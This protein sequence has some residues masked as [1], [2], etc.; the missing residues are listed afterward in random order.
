MGS[1]SQ[2]SLDEAWPET[3]DRLAEM[4]RKRGVARAHIEDVVQETAVRVVENS[5]VFSD[6]EDLLRWA[7]VVA[8]RIALDARRRKKLPI[9]PE[10]SLDTQPAAED[11]AHAA[12]ARYTVDK[13]ATAFGALTPRE[14][15]ALSVIGTDSTGS[16]KADVRLNV[17]RL[18]ARARLRGLMDGLAGVVI[19]L[20]HAWRPRRPPIV[21]AAAVPVVLVAALALPHM[22]GPALGD[23]RDDPRTDAPAASEGSR[24]NEGDASFRSPGPDPLRGASAPGPGSGPRPSLLSQFVMSTDEG[25]AHV[26]EMPIQVYVASIAF[27]GAHPLC[28]VVVQRAPYDLC[29]NSPVPTT[30]VDV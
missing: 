14:Q 11:V 8:W 1:S 3:A 27:V 2:L 28:L 21:V 4:L 19:G 12:L 24:R 6:T 20:R 17:R 10:A 16:R 25:K 18:R 7:N 9:D 5:V 13:L 23:G 30:R 22:R 15:Q 26:E 29:A